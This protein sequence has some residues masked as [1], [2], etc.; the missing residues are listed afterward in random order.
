[1]KNRESKCLVA[2]R[3]ERESSRASNEILSVGVVP[4]EPDMPPEMTAEPDVLVI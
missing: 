2:Q 4:E 1:M 3:R